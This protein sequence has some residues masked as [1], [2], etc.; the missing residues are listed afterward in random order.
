[1]SF[2]LDPDQNEVFHLEVFRSSRL[3]QFL[4]SSN[5]QLSRARCIQLIEDGRVSV[6]GKIIRK[7]SYKLCAGQSVILKV[8]P[9]ICI[10]TPAQDLGISVIYEDNDLLIL[11]KPPGVLTHPLFDGQGGSMV[12]AALHL[13]NELSGINGKLRPG[14][15]H[16]LDRETSGVLVMA[17]N[18]FA[19]KNL[20]K[21]FQNRKV[22]K[23]YFAITYGDPI[24]RVGQIDLPLAR[25]PK[26]RMLRKV[27]EK[28]RSALTKY[29]IIKSWRRFHLVHLMPHTGRT[30]QLRVHLKNIGIP[31]VQDLDYNGRS[32]SR[33]VSRVQ[34]HH[35]SI[36]LFHPR[37]GECMLFRCP[38]L[39]DM[40]ALISHL[41]QGE[42]Y[43]WS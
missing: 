43:P 12:S 29:R 39:R 36:R 30:H 1:M 42:V 14:V 8:P 10:E 19:H 20:Q 7:K 2:S 21:D 11:E 16:R 5:I 40:R 13:A 24:A 26:K 38:L 32:V 35:F 3:D 31:I 17:K 41:Q 18:D 4:S 33:W 22:K 28:G 34:L 15:V 37:T 23:T 27:D 6:N 9:P 25:N